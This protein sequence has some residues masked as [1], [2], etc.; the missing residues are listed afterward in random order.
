[1]LIIKNIRIL[2]PVSGMDRVGDLTIEGGIIQSLGDRALP[3]ADDQ[4]IDGSGLVAAPGLVDVHVHFRDPGLT[5]K[6]DILTGSAAAAAGGYTSVVCMANT[7]P[8]ADN[9]ETVS[10]IVEKAKQA[11][12]HVYTAAAVTKGF[13]GKEL[14]DFERLRTCGAVGFTDDGIPLQDREIVREAMRKLRA[15]DLPISLHE[16]DPSMILRP[17]VHQGSV[18][19]QLGY[20]GAPSASEYTMVER[21]CALALETGA[22]VDIQHISAKETVELVRRAKAAGADVHGEV[23][24]QHFS[25]TEELVLEKGSLA[26][27]NPPLRTEE[28][29]QALIRGLQDGTLDLIATDHA[30]H[31]REEKAGDIKEA[32]SGMIGLETALA[33]GITQLVRPGYLTLPQLLE[34]M[35]VNPAKLYKLDAGELRVGGPADLVIFDEKEQWT[36]TDDFVSKANNSPFIGWKLVGRVK[37]TICNG[38]IV[39]QR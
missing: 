14:T 21:D 28:D 32:P 10:Y 6:E 9:E 30:P 33:L 24:P 16:E 13:H 20:G 25:A 8:V 26:R 15:M 2:D 23:T 34:K 37:Y 31:S 3:N 5:Y 29:R 4:I 38:E 18:A 17:G 35:T 12:I 22:K 36:V 27:V 7:K 19:E 1:M 11:G 39:F